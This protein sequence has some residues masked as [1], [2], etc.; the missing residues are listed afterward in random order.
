[1]P[2]KLVI[3]V[4]VIAS[5]AVVVGLTIFLSLWYTVW[6]GGK[7][8]P[9]ETNDELFYRNVIDAQRIDCHPESIDPSQSVCEERGCFWKN[10]ELDE[11]APLCFYPPS[12]GYNSI[13]HVTTELGWVATISK[14]DIVGERG[15]GL[16]IVTLK[17]SLERQT[18][19]RLRLKIY[20]A[21]STRYEV[22]PESV[23]IPTP[24]SPPTD[25]LYDVTYTEMPFGVMITRRSTGITIFD[26]TI[27]GMTFE[28]QFIQISAA[29]STN[30]I[31]GFGE[32]VHEQYHHDMNWKTWGIFARNPVFYYGKPWNLYGYQPFFMGVEED[33]TAFGVLMLNSNGMDV[34]LSPMPAVTY[35]MIGGVIDLYI[36]LGP[37]PESV[38][39]QYVEAVG[40]PMMP[41]YWALGFQ[42]SRW[43]YNSLDRV[44]EVVEEMR[45]AEIPFDVQYGDIDYMEGQRDWT[46]DNDTYAGLPEYVDQLHNWGMK[47]IIIV[48]PGIK[49]EPGNP[50]FDEGVENDVFIKRPSGDEY[51]VGEVWPGLVH[52]PD[53]THPP[54]VE[55]WTKQNK[56]FYEVLKYDALWIDMNE[57]A[58]FVYGSPEGCPI[59]RWNNPP[60]LSRFWL[61]E[62]DGGH[63]WDKTICMDNMQAWSRHYNVHS[64]YGHSMSIATRTALDEIF[65]SRR[66][67]VL[68]RS[69]FT[70]SGHYA[71]HWTG[72]NKS[73][74][75]ALGHSIPSV[76]E[77][78]MFGFPYVGADICGF[79]YNTTEELCHRWMELGAFYPFARNHN[80]RDTID[81]HPTVWTDVAT[82]SREVLLIRYRLLPFLYTLFYHA[83]TEGSTVARPLLHEFPTDVNTFT[84]DRQFLWG[85]S[86]MISPATEEGQLSVEAYFPEARWYDYRT[87]REEDAKGRLEV[88]SAPLNYI[89]LHIRGGYIIPVQEPNVTTEASRQNSLGL[90][91][92][93]GDKDNYAA[94]GD[95]FWDDGQS[96]DSVITGQ[97]TYSQYTV[98]SNSSSSSLRMTVIHDEL[99]PTLSYDSVEILG[100][101]AEPTMVIVDKESWTDVSFNVTTKVLTLN[102]LGLSMT[103]D[104]VIT[105]D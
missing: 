23:N 59:N 86:F 44:K 78:S 47:Y 79:F 80:T 84:I 10:V 30:H 68:T 57:P 27:G 28:E 102:N 31:F 58:N 105:W 71:G 85:P 13:E 75:P 1:M 55:W 99:H 9:V 41:P 76:L 7:E 73:E 50:A 3:L 70:G 26:T 6:D 91:V 8:D 46:I 54:T 65:P 43:E 15:Y 39:Q 37:S 97:Y 56:Q 100:L 53:Y 88:L 49:I 92:A 21:F 77:M 66:S 51:A 52:Y 2:S 103:S 98:T 87:G 42:L 24:E 90:I 89:P 25:P 4:S 38:V 101:G 60:Y 63:I 18:N 36:F 29:L 82:T 11:L 33:G 83:H 19:Q 14:A 104:H 16:P 5:C 69:T 64:M 17:A 74:W 93:L 20:D 67:M 81:Q 35:R 94:N 95:L 72:D 12:F 34:A 22:P 48:D 62:T 96:K 40:M 45:N 32:H 61:Y